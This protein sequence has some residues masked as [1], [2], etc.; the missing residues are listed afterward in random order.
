[1]RAYVEELRGRPGGLLPS[2][3]GGGAAVAA[4]NTLLPS[5]RAWHVKYYTIILDSKRPVGLGLMAA[6]SA[7]SGAVVLGGADVALRAVLGRG[8]G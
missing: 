5:R 4:I 2:A 6:A 7:L 1:M 8:I 3:F